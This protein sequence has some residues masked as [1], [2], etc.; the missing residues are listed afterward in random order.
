[1]RIL[2]CLIGRHQRSRGQAHSGPN[3]YVSVCR[4]C[5]APMMKRDGVWIA[6]P[7]DQAPG[8]DVLSGASRMGPCKPAPGIARRQVNVP[9]APRN[10][11]RR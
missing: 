4:H 3:G 10:P 7:A 5:H 2:L 9:D 1:M 8:P 11:G 6:C